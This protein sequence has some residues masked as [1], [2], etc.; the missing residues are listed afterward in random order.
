MATGER[1]SAMPSLGR[2]FALILLS[3]S[4]RIFVGLQGHSGKASPPMYGDFEAQRHWIEVTSHLPASEWYVGAHP[5]NSLQYW[6]LDYPP[7]TAYH[8]KLM[9][10]VGNAIQPHSFALNI[11]RGAE[12]E[13][14]IR[15]MRWSVIVSDL[16]VYIPAM[17]LFLMTQES[18]ISAFAFALL[19]P[20]LLLVDHG[21]FQYNGVCLGLVALA[22]TLVTGEGLGAQLLGS[23]MFVLALNFKH[24]A[25][26]YAA[27]FF[28][29]LLSRNLAHLG[30]VVLIGVVVL[31]VFAI[32]WFP[33]LTT[34]NGFLTVVGRLF[35]LERGLF[36]DKVANAWCALGPVLRL[37]ERVAPERLFG[38]AAGATLAG[39]APGCFFLLLRPSRRMFLLALSSISLAFFLFAF[40]VHEKNI[41][42]PLL[43]LTLL[44]GAHPELVTWA[45]TV[46]LFSMFPL[47][48]RDNLSLSY[49]A[50]LMALVAGLGRFQRWSFLSLLLP[51]TAL[52]GLWAFRA[53][54]PHLPHLWIM[55]IMMYCFLCFSLLYLLL[56]RLQWREWRSGS[57]LNSKQFRKVT[58]QE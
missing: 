23:A 48:A 41:L 7:L 29:L 1:F 46:G 52:H 16:L 21:H 6:G 38:L 44:F 32:L 18:S 42:M 12:D 11:S 53:P 9:G 40:Q 2:V 13:A 57:I 19:Q 8:S 54:P 27:A 58:K 10:L 37:R 28:C 36:E 39:I 30:R 17:V 25:M 4:V 31:S 35:P 49:L 55:L 56:L 43:P 3:V 45:V 22:I 33:F 5:A 26:Y 14:T 50:S 20:A 15:F 24:M 47:F 34:P 51:L